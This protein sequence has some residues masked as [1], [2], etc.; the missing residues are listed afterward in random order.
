MR[1]KNGSGYSARHGNIIEDRVDS[2]K[3]SQHTWIKTC[4]IKYMNENMQNPEKQRGNSH[5][6]QQSGKHLAAVE[7]GPQENDSCYEDEQV[8]HVNPHLC[9]HIL[10]QS[11]GGTWD[12]AL[13]TVRGVGSGSRDV[14]T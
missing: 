5:H 14:D 1:K 4:K 13:Y 8:R 6:H 11:G 9:T 2:S 3:S 12:T 7:R 10:L